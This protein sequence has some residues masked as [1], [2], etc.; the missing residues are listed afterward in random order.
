MLTMKKTIDTVDNRFA[1]KK[2]MFYIA[3]HNI[4]VIFRVVTFE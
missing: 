4:L 1:S 2:Q 3:V